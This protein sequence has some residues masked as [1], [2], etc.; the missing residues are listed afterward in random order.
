MLIA[1]GVVLLLLIANGLFVAAEFAIIGAPRAGIEHQA[2]Q[3]SRLARR[4]APRRR[5][6][7]WVCLFHALHGR[8]GL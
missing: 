1:L 2:A 8:R 7:S 3:G 5:V 6:L 4:V